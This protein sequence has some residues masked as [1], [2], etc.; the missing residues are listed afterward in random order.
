MK[1][2]FPKLSE[3]GKNFLVMAKARDETVS[4][5]IG[6][7]KDGS[8]KDPCGKDSKAFWFLLGYWSGESNAEMILREKK[9]G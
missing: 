4:G 5:G 1:T 8:K 2:R 7:N 6:H 9:D 3:P